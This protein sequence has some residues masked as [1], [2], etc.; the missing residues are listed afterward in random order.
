LGHVAQAD[1]LLELLA[2]LGTRPQWAATELALRLEITERTVR[3]DV[4]RLRE[5]GYPIVAAPGL[6]GG[7]A[8]GAGGKL[9][10][11]LLD[12]DEAVAVAIG[13]SAATGTGTG[14]SGLEDSAVSALSKLDRVLPPR[15]RERVGALRQVTLALE[16]PRL[17]A[18]D[19]DALVLMAVACQR[20]ERVRFDY[21]D[22]D[23]RVSQRLVEPFRLVFTDRRWYAVCFDTGRDDWRTFRLDR[24]SQLRATGQSFVR[25]AVP[26]AARLVAEGV[27]VRGY[28][29]V[30]TVRLEAA[31][32]HAAQLIP[33]TVGVVVDSDDDWTTVQIGGDPDWVA[34]YLAG[35]SCR[36]EVV[37]PDAV[38]TELRALARRLIRDHP[39][40]PSA[41]QGM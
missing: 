4:T 31:R 7:Y 27:A 36:F 22:A 19:T 20:P 35:L 9:P 23:G 12:D 41:A 14:N 32:D 6:H 10:P 11:L 26:D 1:R 15:L 17:P 39:P 37:S 8:L 38:R 5:I 28:D 24:I 29:A 30:A 18:A 16:R 13:L 25:G 33:P 3:R 2:L 40:L 21:R 34:R